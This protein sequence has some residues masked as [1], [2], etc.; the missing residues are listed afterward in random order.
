MKLT[1]YQHACF[2][3]EKDGASLVVDPG[4]YSHDFIIPHHVEAVVIT[5]E[6]QDHFDEK[7]IKAILEAHPKATIVAPEGIT[8]R[9]TNY[10][11][12]AAKPGETHTVGSFTV[13]FFGGVHAT[14]ADS[15]PVPA[16]V[17]VFIDGRLYYPGDSFALPEGVAV[18][19]LALPASAPWLKLSEPMAFLAQVHP[20]FAFPTHDA[21]LSEEGKQL[22]DSML[23]SVASG[24]HT[25]YKRLDG[26]SIELS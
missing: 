12:L 9:Y 14:I 6:H 4:A 13:Q 7:H 23:G 11:T 1:K 17:G 26:S 25:T 20:Q 15:I 2:V 10:S 22:T 21:I 19:E 16:N 3:L 8:G 24:Q 18:K 5:H